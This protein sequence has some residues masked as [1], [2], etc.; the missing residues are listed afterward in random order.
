MISFPFW[1][2]V[3]IEKFQQQLPWKCSIGCIFVLAIAMAPLCQAKTRRTLSHLMPAASWQLQSAW[4][5][6]KPHPEKYYWNWI[7]AGKWGLV[8][9]CMLIGAELALVNGHGCHWYQPLAA[10]VKIWTND[11]YLLWV[12]GGARRTEQI[13]F[14]G[15]GGAWAT[16]SRWLQKSPMKIQTDGIWRHTPVALAYGCTSIEEEFHMIS[17]DSD[18][19]W[20][21]SPSKQ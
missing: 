16:L 18:A 8:H 12:W 7:D 13:C 1:L 14:P 15:E 6:S 5:C 4:H 2:Q 11:L 17:H 10:E 19:L 21:G 3:S 9:L 20:K